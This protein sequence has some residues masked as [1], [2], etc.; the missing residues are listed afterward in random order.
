MTTFTPINQ[1]EDEE[2]WLELRR[3]GIGGSD[4]GAIMGMNK[5]ASPLTV[6]MQKKGIDT[7]K[8]NNA[9]KWGHILEDPIRKMTEKELGVT[10]ETV[11]GMFTSVENPFMNANLDGICHAENQVTIDGVTVQGVGGHEI[12]TSGNGE[13]FGDDEIPDSYWAQCQHYMAVMGYSWFILTVFFLTSR[14]GKHYIV[15]RNDNFIERLIHTEKDFWFKFVEQNEFP[16]PTGIEQEAEYLKT[17]KIAASVELDE[18]GEQLVYQERALAEKIKEIEKQHEAVK[19]QI[20][21][22]LSQASN[23]ISSSKTIATVGNYK[24]SLTEQVRK[25]VDTT[26]LKADGL[27]EQYAKESSCKVLRISGG[28]GKDE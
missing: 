7:F 28:K 3:T 20:L 2:K 21:I 8:G 5:Y 23:G 13:G 15:E 18:E 6:F 14:T 4:A 25:S 24:I 12:K 10:I 16:A 19:N 1:F 26:K 11:D 22:K 27:Y 9:T 17:L